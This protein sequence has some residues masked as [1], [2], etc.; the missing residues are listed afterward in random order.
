MIPTPP[1]TTSWKPTAL[2]KWL[3]A[4][5]VV[6]SPAPIMVRI[7][8]AYNGI[9]YLPVFL[10]AM[11][12]ATAIRLMLYDNPKRSMPAAVGDLSLHAS[13]KIAYQSVLWSH[14]AVSQQSTHCEDFTYNLRLPIPRPLRNSGC[15]HSRPS[16][17]C[18][19]RRGP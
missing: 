3:S 9:R 1:P 15:S 2:A 14:M 12:A 7:Q 16:S 10:T 11:P 13:K 18:A 4:R 5:S 8:P 6:R 17:S 19:T